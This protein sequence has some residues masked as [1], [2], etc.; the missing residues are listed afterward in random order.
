MALPLPHRVARERRSVHQHAR[1]DG[2]AAEESVA[3]R[4]AKHLQHVEPVHLGPRYRSDR[5]GREEDVCSGLLDAELRGQKFHV[6]DGEVRAV[7][8]W[9]KGTVSFEW[10]VL[11]LCVCTLA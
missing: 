2:T 3:A 11:D 10:N 8:Y 5:F 9:R 1:T 6:N 7:A 4:R